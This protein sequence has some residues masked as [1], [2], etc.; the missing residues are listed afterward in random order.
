MVIWP[1][2][3]PVISNLVPISGRHRE[4]ESSLLAIK[5]RYSDAIS[6]TVVPWLGDYPPNFVPSRR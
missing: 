5:G 2:L 1:S 4:I 3:L 6:I